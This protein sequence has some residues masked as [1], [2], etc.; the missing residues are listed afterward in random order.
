MATAFE[1]RYRLIENLNSRGSSWRNV[2]YAIIST[3]FFL[4]RAVRGYM[5]LRVMTHRLRI[6]HQT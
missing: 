2:I 4:V 6:L 3:T 5:A 1:M